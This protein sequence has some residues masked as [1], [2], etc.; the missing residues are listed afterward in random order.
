[1][2]GEPVAPISRNA[3]VVA[4]FFQTMPTTLKFMRPHVIHPGTRAALD[5]LTA[6]GLLVV[7]RDPRGPMEWKAAPSLGLLRKFRHPEKDEG[8]PLTIDEDPPN[9]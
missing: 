9:A 8:F 4:W 2:E 5:E 1:M 7:T 3:E 6:A